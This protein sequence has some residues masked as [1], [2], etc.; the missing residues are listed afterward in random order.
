VLF[1]NFIMHKK[2]QKMCT[3]YFTDTHNDY[4][5]FLLNLFVIFPTLFNCAWLVIISLILCDCIG[6][7][8]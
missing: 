3:C 4:I 5:H 6:N 8:D 2:Q 7:I 1:Q